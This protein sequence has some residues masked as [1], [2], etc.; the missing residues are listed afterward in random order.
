MG[1]AP[2]RE[3]IAGIRPEHFVAVQPNTPGA[4][5]ITIELLEPTGADTYAM[6]RIGSK[7]VTLR[8]APKQAPRVGE[9]AW[10]TVDPAA[11]NWF[12]PKT[13]QRIAV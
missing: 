3:V 10:V 5:P 9:T 7:A 1:Q 12:D 8:F 13:E 11:V 4:L 2:Y 6:A